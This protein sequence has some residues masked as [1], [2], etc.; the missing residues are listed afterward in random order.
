MTFLFGWVACDRSLI[1]FFLMSGDGDDRFG[2]GG[3]CVRDNLS[4]SNLFRCIS[5]ICLFFC[6]K[7][8]SK[9]DVNY[10]VIIINKTKIML[11]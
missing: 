10:Y 5:V 8:A 9:K 3:W 2:V 4:D 11:K 6:L 1:F 7:N